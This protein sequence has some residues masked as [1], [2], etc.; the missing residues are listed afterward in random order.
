MRLRLAHLD[1]ARREFIA[2]ASH[3]LR[4]PLFSLGG[5][6]RAARRRGA[7]RADAARVPRRRCASRS[8]RL[9]KLATDL[10]DLSRLDAGRLTVD[11]RAGRPGARCAAD[12]AEE[13]G[14]L[15]A[16]SGHALA[17]ASTGEARARRG[18]RAARAPDRPDPGR[19]RA[20]AHAAGDAGRDP[21]ARAWRR[22][23]CSRSRT[24][25][26]G[27]RAEQ[28]DA[29]VRALLPR[30]T[31]PAP[32]AAAS[33]SRS[34]SELAELMDGAIELESR[35]GG[36]VFSLVLPARRR[37]RS[38]R[39]HVKT[40]LSAGRV[41]TVSRPC[42]PRRLL[43]SPSSAPCSA[44]SPRSGS[45]SWPAGSDR[46]RRPR[47]SAPRRDTGLPATAAAAAVAPNAKP[48][49]GNGFEPERD[50]R[51]RAA[52]VVTIFSVFGTD[53]DDRHAGPGLRLR[54][55]AEGLHPHQLA[56][57]HR[58]RQT[59]RCAKPRDKVYVEFQ[60]GDRVPGIDRRLGRLRRRRPDQGRSRRRTRSC[61]C[62]SANSAAVVVGEPV[63]AIGSPFGNEDSLGGRRR[64]GD[65]ALDR[66]ADLELQRSST[67]SRP[68]RRSTTATP[69]A[70]CSTR[71]AA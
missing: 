55:L 49:A 68:T 12:L 59:A 40:A 38:S 54:R 5:L 67:R 41:A 22:A 23:P 57:D 1:D 60:D 17:V 24:R 39:F 7:R 27:I 69:A 61:R 65:A 3:E 29:A 58:R 42:G 53:P 44:A 21:R 16:S 35:P 71:A 14:P 33:G 25:A 30:S 20:A 64:L 45:A 26:A 70:R 51:R 63:A 37:R 8:T 4:T 46:A 15:A 56:R 2:N 50:L 9:T 19:E 47:S 32:R 48:L 62:R 52:G 11:A 18:G 34:P 31:A 6:P 43:P 13:F 28:R 36:T 66:L 10:L